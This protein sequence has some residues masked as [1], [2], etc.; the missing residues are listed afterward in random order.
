MA[1]TYEPIRLRARQLK[2]HPSSAGWYTH[3]KKPIKEAEEHADRGSQA[4]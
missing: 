2:D 1:I 4:Y 3:K